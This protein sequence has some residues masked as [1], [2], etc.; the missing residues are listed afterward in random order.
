MYDETLFE[1]NPSLPGSILVRLFL[2][3]V[4]LACVLT[5]PVRADE[6]PKSLLTDNIE[7]ILAKLGLSEDVVLVG[8]IRQG[9]EVVAYPVLDA[10]G[11]DPF[12]RHLE[13]DREVWKSAGPF[14]SFFHRT[15]L[16]G[17][18]F[19]FSV[20]SKT[21]RPLHVTVQRA[22]D[23]S[24]YYEF[25]IDRFSPGLKQPWNVPLHAIEEVLM[26]LVFGT[27]TDQKKIRNVLLH[28]GF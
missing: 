6:N 16:A 15:A 10:N 2:A 3:F 5:M 11:E 1:S 12:L 18:R 7:R 22:G 19:W 14:T 8:E 4:V 9:K 26:H 21:V 13:Q 17:Y 23:G 24:Y 20:R 27:R 25:D 28:H